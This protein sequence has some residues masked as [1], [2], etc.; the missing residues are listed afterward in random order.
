[1]YIFLCYLYML[2]NY[3]L[4]IEYMVNKLYLYTDGE[5]WKNK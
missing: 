1:M 4:Y 3:I 5:K 2:S